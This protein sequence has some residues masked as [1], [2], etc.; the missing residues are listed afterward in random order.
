MYE[1]LT[2]E[3]LTQLRT[4]LRLA[5]H[6]LIAGGQSA[7]IRYGEHGEKFHAASP[8]LVEAAISKINAE[9]A[10]RTGAAR[11]GFTVLHGG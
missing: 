9:L 1:D 3:Q 8:A 5:Y 6:S 10:R 11:G 2:V 4:D 7:E